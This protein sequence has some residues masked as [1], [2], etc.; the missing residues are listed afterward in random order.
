MIPEIRMKE[1]IEIR[2]STDVAK[3]LHVYLLTHLIRNCHLQNLSMP[4]KTQ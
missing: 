2:Q 3:Y 1:S 4:E